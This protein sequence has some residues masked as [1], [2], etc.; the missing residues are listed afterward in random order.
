[1]QTP[2]RLTSMLVPSGFPAFPKPNKEDKLL[3]FMY[4]SD[5]S[6][7]SW[8]NRLIT[9]HKVISHSVSVTDQWKWLE[10]CC[11]NKTTSSSEAYSGLESEALTRSNYFTALDCSGVWAGAHGLD[12]FS[13]G[14]IKGDIHFSRQYLNVYKYLYFLFFFKLAN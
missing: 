12:P 8:P 6:S 7:S 1:M 2:S 4:S 14:D 11:Q 10:E 5:I 9:E 13:C 3:F